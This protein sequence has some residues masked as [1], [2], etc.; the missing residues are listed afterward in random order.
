MQDIL[1]TIVG[2][3]PE[4]RYKVVLEANNLLVSMGYTGHEIGITN[5]MGGNPEATG[6]EFGES[7]EY[8]YHESVSLILALF[9]IRIVDADFSLSALLTILKAIVGTE[10]PLNLDIVAEALETNNDPLIL[11]A[12]IGGK[13]TEMDETWFME[14]LDYVDESLVSKLRLLTYDPELV[15]DAS[16]LTAEIIV[17]YKAFMKGSDGGLVAE[18]AGSVESLPLSFNTAYFS[19][20]ED[21]LNLDGPE[22]MSE[23]IQMGI[24]ANLSLEDIYEKA[25]RLVDIEQNSISNLDDAMR[26]LISAT[27]D[28]NG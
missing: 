6:M 25:T 19:L 9:G 11:L 4:E 20:R 3:I 23:V 15:D 5:I 10:D 18:I 2:L 14:R 22:Y 24:L 12:A 13:L 16:K 28:N 7:V 1:S 21:L 8:I 17:R 27:G 26:T